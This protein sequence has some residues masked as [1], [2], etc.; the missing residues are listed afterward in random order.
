[1]QKPSITAVTTHLYK[2][3]KKLR[4]LV[5]ADESGERHGMGRSPAPGA[6]RARNLR[7]DR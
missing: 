1:M 6:R 5:L 3:M 7:S 4:A 2:A